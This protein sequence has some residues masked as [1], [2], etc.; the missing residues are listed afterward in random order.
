MQPA[1]LAKGQAPGSSAGGPM[2]FVEAEGGIIFKVQAGGACCQERSP[3]GLRPE[4]SPWWSWRNLS[5]AFQGRDCYQT[6][7]QRSQRKPLAMVA[8]WDLGQPSPGIP[9]GDVVPGLEVG[10]SRA[11]FCLEMH[12]F[13]H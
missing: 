7:P 6:C 10:G 4:L 8:D 9:R 1:K 11:V 12:F 5:S 13:T 2:A 3:N